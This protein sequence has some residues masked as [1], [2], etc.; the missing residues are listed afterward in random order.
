MTTMKLVGMVAVFAGLFSAGCTTSDEVPRTRPQCNV[1]ARCT[2][3]CEFGE[4][5]ARIQGQR[6]T[7]MNSPWY[8]CAYSEGASAS[9]REYALRVN[10]YVCLGDTY[11]VEPWMLDMPKGIL[12]TGMSLST[13]VEATLEPANSSQ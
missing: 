9:T 11:T 3:T 13:E 5:T 12:C 1:D 4:Y 8:S 2:A 6:V 10:S 7:G